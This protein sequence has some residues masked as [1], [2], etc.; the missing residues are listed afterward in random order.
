MENMKKSNNYTG[1]QNGIK[2]E[3]NFLSEFNITL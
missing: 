3:N 1:N 2:N